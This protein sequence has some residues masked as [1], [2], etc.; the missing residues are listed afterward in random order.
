MSFDKIVFS[1]W[2]AI[3][4]YLFLFGVVSLIIMSCTI[5]SEP[6]MSIKM[7]IFWDVDDDIVIGMDVADKGVYTDDGTYFLHGSAHNYIYHVYFDDMLKTEEYM[8]IPI[9][10]RYY[11]SGRSVYLTLVDSYTLESVDSLYLG[12]DVFIRDMVYNKGMLDVNY[13]ILGIHMSLRLLINEEGRLH[14]VERTW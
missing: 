3:I 10:Y 7:P 8:F 11:G 4:V 5:V 13:G 1:P 14:V 2:Y 9:E 6:Q 12:N